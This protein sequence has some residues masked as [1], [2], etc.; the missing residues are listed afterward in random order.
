MLYL[1]FVCIIQDSMEESSR[2][3]LWS[4]P[5]H[6]FSTEKERPAEADVVVIVKAYWTNLDSMGKLHL[7]SS[8]MTD[9]VNDGEKF[10]NLTQHSLYLFFVK[11]TQ[12]LH[13][14]LERCHT[15]VR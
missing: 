7:L 8:M 5:K 4:L 15:E 14:D 3:S 6:L 12:G 2:A 13:S 10:W 9:I 1:L 11:M